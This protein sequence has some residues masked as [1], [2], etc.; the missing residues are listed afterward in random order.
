[1]KLTGAPATFPLTRRNAVPRLD[2]PGMYPNAIVS[3]VGA[4]R[5]AAQ[6]KGIL[7][8]LGF[9]ENHH[10]LGGSGVLALRGIREARGLDVFVSR[11]EY[12]RLLRDR[13][14]I[15]VRD[16]RCLRLWT[17]E[18]GLEVNAFADWN[19]E[20]YVVDVQW[21]VRNPEYVRGVPCCALNYLLDRLQSGVSAKDA[22][23][24]ALIERYLAGGGER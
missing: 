1:M 9:R 16:P 24:V 18:D 4:E 19:S 7:G 13:R 2:S 11:G 10:L 14:W 15:E 23:D 21:H 22:E 5:A 8:G 6:I 3:T 20:G 17:L 12:A